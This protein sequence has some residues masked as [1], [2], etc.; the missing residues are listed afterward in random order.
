MYY[1]PPLN[2][3]LGG[4]LDAR[5]VKNHYGPP[6]FLFLSTYSFY[7]L[8][9]GVLSASEGHMHIISSSP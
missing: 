3:V 8:H 2:E 7:E 1:F 6:W 5:V 4:N 9:V